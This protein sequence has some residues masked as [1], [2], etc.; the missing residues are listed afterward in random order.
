MTHRA[1]KN[2]GKKIK[3]LCIPV[4]AWIVL[5]GVWHPRELNLADRSTTTRR[6][7]RGVVEKE[8]LALSPAGA[9]TWGYSVRTSKQEMLACT[10]THTH[11]HTHTPG[12]RREDQEGRRRRGGWGGRRRRNKGKTRAGMKNNQHK[13]FIFFLEHIL[14]G[15]SLVVQWL[16]FLPQFLVGELRPYIPHRVTKK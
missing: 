11:T 1:G 14:V 16:R 10:H 2:G 5:E 6:G 8:I 3:E 15:T 7:A 4:T 12:A 9:W 13:Y